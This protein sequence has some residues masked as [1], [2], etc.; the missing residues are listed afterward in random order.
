MPQST[1]S[2]SLFVAGLIGLLLL[3]ACQA[4][5]DS[6]GPGSPRIQ[7]PAATGQSLRV[8]IRSA[9]R[10]VAAIAADVTTL[11]ITVR[12]ADGREYVRS[13]DPAASPADDPSATFT[14]LPAGGTWVQVRALGAASET[15]GQSERAVTLEG[16]VTTDVAIALR[17]N[18]TSGLPAPAP[19]SATVGITLVDGP[20]L[21]GPPAPSPTPKLFLGRQLLKWENFAQMNTRVIT[22]SH[23]FVWLFQPPGALMKLAPDAS[24]LADVP[25][26]GSTYWTSLAIDSHDHLWLSGSGKLQKLS[27]TGANLGA[28]TVPVQAGSDGFA[29]DAA[30]QIWVAGGR[31]LARI[32]PTGAVLD[33]HD[34]PAD[35][36]A[37]AV[38]RT[39]GMAWVLLPPQGKVL[40]FTSA[41]T[42]LP[43]VTINQ[44]SD[45]LTALA[46]DA[47]GNA[48][49]G[50]NWSGCVAKIAPDGRHL[51]QFATGNQAGRIVI[52]AQGNVIAGPDYTSLGTEPYA[53][54][55]SPDGRV[56][57]HYLTDYFVH[58]A[59]DAA[60]DLW[61][62]SGYASNVYLLKIAL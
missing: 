24:R 23:G 10:H 55:L 43:A 51:G 11:A 8:T 30:G 44:T 7:L 40:R 48:W 45:L 19:T 49:V 21:T 38:D 17:L 6:A 20:V 26:P 2:R 47:Q 58:A 56:L 28:Y 42:A 27:T 5:P 33:T 3:S 29:M 39:S 1:S 46:V 15:L 62:L 59:I 25:L 37:L 12:A 54:K 57:G 22:D 13:L 16:G 36:G 35:A 18:A 52:D 41:G 34:L 50:Q 31:K 4:M 32:S 9:D 61:S 53:T 60:G 14:G